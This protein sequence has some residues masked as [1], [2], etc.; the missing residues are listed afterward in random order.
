MTGLITVPA[1]VIRRAEKGDAAALAD[2]KKRTF[3]ATFV[4][5]PIAVPYSAENIARFEVEVYSPEAVAA[6]LADPRRAQWVVQDEAGTL[7]AYAHAGPCKLPHPEADAGQGE[8]YQL[9]V[10][11]DWQGHG[12]GRALMDRV[13]DW[14]AE[15]M[16][17]PVWIGVFSENF[18]AQ[19]VYAKRGFA[20][21]GEY[22]FKVGDHRDREYI[23]RRA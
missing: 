21:V 20:K 14:L 10:D 12:L 7:V 15:T 1:P 2:L 17:G 13:L 19:A 11:Q 22:D 23:L 8:L 18:P 9:Y 5:G 4:D 3:R 6:E 16:P